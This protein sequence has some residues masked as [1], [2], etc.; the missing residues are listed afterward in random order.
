MLLVSYVYEYISW[1]SWV[2]CPLLLC[3]LMM[4]AN[5]KAHY[6]LMVVFVYLH[7]TLPHYHYYAD[8][9][10]SIELVKCLSGTFCLK[11]VS[12]IKPI[13]SIIFHGCA[14][15]AYPFCHDDYENM[16]T[17][18]YCHHQTESITLKKKIMSSNG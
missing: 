13:L 8:L 7:I 15:S 2:F 14:Y 9:F 11:Y 6:D 12:K 10:E 17:L 18:S 1:E 16:C 3:S 5:D 4:C